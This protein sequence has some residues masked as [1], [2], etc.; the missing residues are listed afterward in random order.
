MPRHRRSSK[1]ETRAARLRLP[2]RLKPHF[3]QIAPRVGLGYRRNQNAGTWIARGA[4]GKGGYW[5]KAFGH[6]DD[7]EDADG[8]SILTY[9][10]AQDRAKQLVR[11]VGGGERPV[12]VAE[13][14]DHY[15]NDLKRRGNDDSN[16][17]RVR[18]SIPRALANKTVSLLT[19]NDLRHWR[20][21]LIADG[22]KASTADRTARMMKA[23]LNLAARDDQRITNFGAWKTGLSRLPEEAPPACR[24]VA[25]DVVAKIVAAAHARGTDLGLFV[26]TAAVTGARPSQLRNLEVGDLQDRDPLHPALAMPSSKKGRRR[27]ITRQSLPIPTALGKALRH[28]AS[29]RDK[30]SPLFLRESGAARTENDYAKTWRTIV[31]ELGLDPGTTLYSLRHSS[32]VRQLLGGVPARV[33]AAHHDTSLVVLE[34]T[35]SRYITQHSDAMIR[36]SLIDLSGA[37]R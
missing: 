4:D 8:N 24:I 35:Y 5:T 3:M 31:R 23:A 14:L 37:A 12:T 22:V 27:R 19:P 1:L 13:A 33:V 20:D 11:G 32:I 26:E 2:V 30:T 6:A 28:Y 10:Q 25:D 7:H 16:S 29:D 36:G 21:K 15:E 9:Y 34:N 18:R 17:V